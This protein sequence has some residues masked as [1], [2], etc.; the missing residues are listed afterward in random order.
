MHVT[1]NNKETLS[2]MLGKQLIIFND[3]CKLSKD[4]IDR[5]V[6]FF[7]IIFIIDDMINCD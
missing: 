4:S 6:Q 3:K 1:E 2:E 7:I 5:D